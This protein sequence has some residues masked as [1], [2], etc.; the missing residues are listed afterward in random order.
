LNAPV[1]RLAFEFSAGLLIL[2]AGCG[3]VREN[4]LL[5]FPPKREALSLDVRIPAFCDTL[6]FGGRGT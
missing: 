6:A 4:P 3:A 1:E 5:V 2:L